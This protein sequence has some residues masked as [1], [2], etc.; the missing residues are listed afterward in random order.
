MNLSKLAPVRQVVG[1]TLSAAILLGLPAADRAGAA[2]FQATPV[3]TGLAFPAGFTFAPNGRIFYGERFTGEVR[4]LNPD[5]S[6]DRLFFT[7]P[8][9]VTEGEQGLLGVALHPNYPERPYVYVSVVRRVRG[10]PKNQILRI[11]NAGGTGT[12][13]RVIF[14]GGSSTTTHVGGRILFGPDRMLYLVVGDKQDPNRSQRLANRAGKV[15]R[16][17]A[18]GQ[19][20]ARNP[21]SNY[22]F[23]YGIRNSFGFAFDPQTDLMWESENGPSCNDELN[24]IIRGGNFGWGPSWTCSTPP[25]SP[26]NTN[27]DGPNPVLPKRFYGPPMI[28]PTGVVFCSGCGLGSENEGRLFFG[29]WNNG[30]ITRVTLNSTRRSVSSQ[31]IIFDHTSGI[32]AMERGPDGALYFSDPSSIRRLEMA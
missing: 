8:D 5:T 14:N 10:E 15:L 20:P 28:A 32:L 31:S 12:D 16:M 3:A 7:V 11:R 26:A 13:L 21:F 2:T 24:R 4:I 27:Q 22:T 9:V 29:A 25:G 30:Q 23:A 17:T 6:R 19:I 18:G 1:I